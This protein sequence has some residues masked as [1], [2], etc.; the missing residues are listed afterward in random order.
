MK[1]QRIIHILEDGRRK[2]STHNGEI[3]LWTKHEVEN[4]KRNRAKYGDGAYLADFSRYDIE[5]KNLRLRYPKAK[6]IKIVG[7]ENEDHD[8]PIDPQIIF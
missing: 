4:L 6:I 2:Y 7:F 5:A 8:L 1:Y 3:E